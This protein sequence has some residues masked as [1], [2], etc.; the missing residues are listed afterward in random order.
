[1]TSEYRENITDGHF[2]MHSGDRRFSGRGLRNP[3]AEGINTFVFN[4]GNAQRVSIDGVS[5]TM[6]AQSILPLV[7][8]Q[9]FE[10]EK[11]ER[12]VA[13]QFNRAFYCILDHDA[14]VGCV[15]FLFYG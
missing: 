1:M 13:W 9:H 14:E 6:P 3:T 10:F 11:P 7:S 5:Y 15:G 12:L 2:V 8:Q 4:K